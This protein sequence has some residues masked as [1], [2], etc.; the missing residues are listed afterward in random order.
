MNSENTLSNVIILT[1]GTKGDLYPFIHIGRGL[2]ERGHEV[3]LLSNYSYKEYAKQEG[4]DFDFVA[5]DED[6]SFQTMIEMTEFYNKLPSLIQLYKDH[7]IP[8]LE[9]ELEVI[10]AK[11]RK[12]KTV[13][14]AHSNYYFSAL[15]AMEKLN[16]PLY[17]GVLS[18]S[19]IYS[20]PLFEGIAKKLSVELNTVRVR[21]G[22]APVHD[23]KKWLNSYNQCFALWP[24]WFSNEGKQILSK[25]EYVG[26]LSV[27]GLDPKPLQ[28]NIKAFVSDDTT[29]ILI[30]HGTSRPFNDNY[31]RTTIK[32]CETLK[33]KLIVSTP[34]RE[35]LPETLSDNIIWVDYCPFDELLPSIDL[36]IHHGGIGTTREAAANSVPQLII[37]QGFDRQDNGRIVKNLGLGDCII[38][39]ALSEELLFNT[40]RRLLH[41]NQIKTVCSHYAPLLKNQKPHDDFYEKI[42]RIEPVQSIDDSFL[43]Y[44][45]M[46]HQQDT[47]TVASEKENVGDKSSMKN[48]SLNKQALLLQ[49]LKNKSTLNA[50]KKLLSNVSISQKM[51]GTPLSAAQDRIWKMV[52]IDPENP[53]YRI[54]KGYQLNG[55]LNVE[56]LEK[57]FSYVIQQQE[58]LRTSFI[59]EGNNV[60]QILNENFSFDLRYHD[61]KNI[62]ENEQR[63]LLR[64]M[65]AEDNKTRFD[66]SI[67]PLLRARLVTLDDRKHVLILTVHLIVSDAHSLDL[68]LT[69]LGETYNK[70]CKD[71]A[72]FQ[73][74]IDS[75]P[76]FQE[77]HADYVFQQEQLFHQGIIDKQKDYWQQ[78]LAGIRNSLGF[79]IDKERTEHTAHYGDYITF[80]LGKK[81]TALIKSSAQSESASPFMFLMTAYNI[82]CL[83]FTG[84]TDIVLGNPISNRK[85][86]DWQSLVGHFSNMLILRNMF[87]ENM[88]V[89]DALSVVRKNTLDAFANQD[90]PFEILADL[91]RKGGYSSRNPIVRNTFGFQNFTNGLDSWDSITIEVRH[92]DT[93]I[94]KYELEMFMWEQDEEFNAYLIYDTG[95]FEQ[96]SIERIKDAF[97]YILEGML[98]NIERPICMLPLCDE[99]QLMSDKTDIDAPPDSTVDYCLYQQFSA[100]AAMQADLTAIIFNGSRISYGDLNKTVNILARS[101]GKKNDFLLGL[102]IEQSIDSIIAVLALSQIGQPFVFINPDLLKEERDII[103]QSNQLR[104]ILIQPWLI[105]FLEWP[106]DLNC[107]SFS[108]DEDIYPTQQISEGNYITDNTDIAY[109]YE[110]NSTTGSISHSKVTQQQLGR[111]VEKILALGNFS[112]LGS[113][114]LLTHLNKPEA[115][116]EIALS[117]TTGGSIIMQEVNSPRYL[118]HWQA[119]FSN[120]NISHLF[121]TF[122]EF[123][124]L[125]ELIVHDGLA[126]PNSL[127]V[128][129]I[130]DGPQAVHLIDRHYW[131]GKKLIQLRSLNQSPYAF[132]IDLNC[133]QRSGYWQSSNLVQLMVANEALRACPLNVPGVLYSKSAVSWENTG[134]NARQISLK[135]W[136]LLGATSP[137]QEEDIFLEKIA[138][139]LR[140]HTSVRYS[141][142]RHYKGALRAYVVLTGFCGEEAIATL[143]Q[144]LKVRLADDE[145]P[146]S[147]QAIE[148]L[149]L[150]SNK[151][152]NWEAL[153]EPSYKAKE[154]VAPTSEQEAVVLETWSEILD[155]PKS[156]ICVNDNFFDL[157]GHSLLATQVISR[158][159]QR[160]KIKLP[161]KTLFENPT[162]AALSS[163]IILL[164]PTKRNRLII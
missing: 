126:I 162:I 57:S 40:I 84:R 26:F 35:L 102:C 97:I 63:N 48:L 46:N 154:I 31:F 135:E 22:L 47:H 76:S 17:L 103:I 129:F 86:K 112:K 11:V 149:P 37:G 62:E 42:V 118:D 130:N 155:I 105:D 64:T 30:T 100:Q 125:Q 146:S 4:F 145:V 55:S 142:V 12:G 158:I 92:L 81:L 87:S 67:A 59:A 43:E 132:Y 58:M 13:I 160:F 120:N 52:Q 131:S 65:V 15:F 24:D 157:G 20:F 8:N 134:L 70:L 3:T 127:S 117:L 85:K 144:H 89:K 51:S 109:F 124:S 38:P 75:I 23:W 77:Q 91:A 10:E 44:S 88:S 152:I 61:L 50:D 80:S 116:T 111:S 114:P 137:I 2:K 54:I 53:V 6:E 71:E 106:E 128:L 99:L 108:Y 78:H 60:K 25:L 66:L 90:I 113:A 153:P 82:L 32:V 18:P 138:N 159:Q 122:D 19:F 74:E 151:Q 136:E 21:I 36:I 123:E 34:F 73:T 101:L 41:D 115:L 45:N 148:R 95:L 9:K 83:R 133:T 163:E 161:L 69:N 72:I 14:L 150:T 27:D 143:Y 104:Q 139:A 156:K 140:S 1:R 147:I 5:L 39:K 110:I 28:E 94:A 49:M 96:S 93:G 56:L 29:C 121:L 16:I 107:L 33:C 68:I 164:S 98:D 79:P 7:I 141:L 119:L